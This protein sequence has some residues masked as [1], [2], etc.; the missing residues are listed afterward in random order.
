MDDTLIASYMEKEH[1]EHIKQVF[2]WLQSYKKKLKLSK[3]EFLRNKIHFLGHTLNYPYL[4]KMVKS[5]KSKLQQMP[6]K[7]THFWN[8]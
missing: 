8:S 1:L 7:Y 3:C 5:Q 6:M 4:R 2:E